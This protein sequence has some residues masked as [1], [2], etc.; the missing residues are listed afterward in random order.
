MNDGTPGASA[1]IW[2]HLLQTGEWKSVREVSDALP[3][4]DRHKDAM[5]YMA[6]AGMLTRLEK[7][8]H[9]KYA[10]TLRC[11]VPRAVT[12]TQINEALSEPRAEDPQ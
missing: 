12:V 8:G 9:P 6:K 4:L 3:A 11:R 5:A 7:E 1:P 10:V 2:L